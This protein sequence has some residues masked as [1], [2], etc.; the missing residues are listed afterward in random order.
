MNRTRQEPSHASLQRCD[1]RTSEATR[2][3]GRAPLTTRA[4][5]TVERMI[6]DGSPFEDIEQYI[7][8]LALPS[9]AL[10]A[11][12]LLAWAEATDLLTRRRVVAE[13]LAGPDGLPGPAPAVTP[14][15]SAG[16]SHERRRLE[17][18]RRVSSSSPQRGRPRRQ[19][20][21]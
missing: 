7:E 2:A 5:A 20:S 3:G 10:G 11:L 16:T 1:Q 12:W 4:Q 9:E 19:G 6:A 8:T 21:S 13:V 18:V 15:A 17:S 14:G